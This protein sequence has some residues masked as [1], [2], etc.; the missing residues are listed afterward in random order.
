MISIEDDYE[1]QKSSSG[2]QGF[3]KKHDSSNGAPS[4]KPLAGMGLTPRGE[5]KPGHIPFP[6]DD[7]KVDFSARMQKRPDKKIEKGLVILTKPDKK[8]L[9]IKSSDKVKSNEE[10]EHL[11]DDI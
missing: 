8:K 7:D 10:V 1:E 6:D 9:G 3:F 5:I 11:V 4:M 2:S